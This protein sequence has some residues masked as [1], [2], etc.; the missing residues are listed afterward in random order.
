MPQPGCVERGA[1]GG[2]YVYVRPTVPAGNNY[3][4]AQMQALTNG[5]NNA[6][7]H[8]DQVDCAT[9]YAGGDDDPSLATAKVLEGTMYRLVLLPQGPGTGAQ[10]I[11]LTNVMINTAGAFFNARANAN[12]TVTVGMPNAAGVQTLFTFAGVSTF[13]AFMLLHELGH[14]V[15]VFGADMNAAANGANSQAVL[16][17]CFRM[18]AQG[19]SLMQ[20]TVLV[21]SRI[22]IL[23]ALS[24]A[25]P[26]LSS[27]QAVRVE[28]QHALAT[29]YRADD[30]DVAAFKLKFDVRLT[31][32]SGGPVDIPRSET[33]HGGTTRVAVLG[34][35]AKRPD[36]RWTH[37]V[38]SSWYDVDTI[39]YESCTSLPPGGAAEFANLP[40]GLLLLNT[41]LAGL[42]NEPTVRFNLMIFCRQ[43]DGKV[44]TT[45]VTTDGFDLR[46]PPR[47]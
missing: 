14:Q 39:K 2:G 27:Q 43:P 26:S 7:S 34:V 11:N 24:G 37:V 47:R 40:S 30:P 33:G 35:Q 3:T 8:T 46:L 36:G 31:N 38:Q 12:G 19:L 17:H 23:A 25:V 32:R 10:T 1:G 44:L 29:P 41:Q 15:G 22:L 6:L 42:G 18:D 4:P 13:E 5:L 9:F 20:Q 16:D 45:T 28:V 21:T